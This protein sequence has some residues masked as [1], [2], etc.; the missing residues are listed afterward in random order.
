MKFTSFVSISSLRKWNNYLN[1]YNIQFC[2]V[3]WK[4]TWWTARFQR[5]HHHRGQVLARNKSNRD[6]RECSWAA[7]PQSRYDSGH[8]SL[9]LYL[10]GIGRQY[11][12]ML[13]VHGRDILRWR[14][15]TSHNCIS[16]TKPQGPEK[17]HTSAQPSGWHSRTGSTELRLTVHNWNSIKQIFT[18]QY[19]LEYQWKKTA[20]VLLQLPA[21]WSSPQSLGQLFQTVQLRFCQLLCLRS[22]HQRT[23]EHFCE[24][25]KSDSNMS[26]TTRPSCR[27]RQ[28]VRNCFWLVYTNSILQFLRVL[29]KKNA[30]RATKI[31]LCRKLFENWSLY[32]LILL[33]FKGLVGLLHHKFEG[34][35]Q[36][37]FSQTGMYL[38][39]YR[40]Y[41][42]WK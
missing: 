12:Y 6:A 40:N 29:C 31:K 2:A 19:K 4:Y 30:F 41:E 17:T 35:V 28:V 7:L 36:E 8:P 10:T 16:W 1:E 24:E 42:I 18:S 27:K 39:L 37:D 21:Q 13:D 25:N 22:S 38:K 26:A 33:A 20:N 3:I 14:Y 23:P 9:C 32:I 34:S 5:T 15:P 11:L